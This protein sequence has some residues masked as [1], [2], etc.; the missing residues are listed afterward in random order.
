MYHRRWSIL[1]A[2]PVKREGEK[3]ENCGLFIKR[4]TII[5]LIP[6]G[7]SAREDQCPLRG[8]PR[9]PSLARESLGIGAQKSETIGSLDLLDQSAVDL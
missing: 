7:R 5:D 6:I 4:K 9:S 3:E 8:S 2:P 1:L